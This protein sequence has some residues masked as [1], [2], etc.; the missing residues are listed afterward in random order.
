MR[1]INYSDFYRDVKNSGLESAAKRSQL[2]G[3]GG[4][5]FLDM[6]PLHDNSPLNKSSAKET[7]KILDAYGQSVACFSVAVNLLDPTADAYI[8]TL[9]RQI[10]FAAELGSKKFHHTIGLTWDRAKALSTPYQTALDI[11]FPRAKQVAERC[12]SY[13]ITCLY[14]PQGYYFNGLDGL[15][16][17]YSKMKQDIP[18]V[19]ICGDVGNCLFAETPATAIYDAFSSDIKHVHIK[20]YLVFDTQQKTPTEWIS[21]GGKYLY[22]CPVGDGV[23]DFPYC[24]QK[25]KAVGYDGDIAFEFEGDDDEV[26]RVM[27]FVQNLW[28]EDLA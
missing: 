12:A 24:F 22:D 11:A 27:A 8:D 19:G 14:E 28:K 9:W 18:N 2:L 7:K 3:F 10:E 1:F 23:T 21:R 4:V 6:A 25:L 13:G 16:V 17:F 20:D 26:R 15:G 5:E